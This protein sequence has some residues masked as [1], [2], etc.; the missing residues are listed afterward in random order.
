MTGHKTGCYYITLPHVWYINHI[1]YMKLFETC[2]M[3][4]PYSLR[5]TE[6]AILFMATLSCYLLDMLNSTLIIKR[7]IGVSNNDS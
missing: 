5:I 7:E 1:S 2:N 3:F 6:F 4:C